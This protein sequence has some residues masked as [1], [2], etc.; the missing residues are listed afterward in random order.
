MLS[1]YLLFFAIRNQTG[2]WKQRPFTPPTRLVRCGEDSMHKIAFMIAVC[3][4][5]LGCG[6]FLPDA[7]I[8][9]RP[10][11]D[12][13]S[14]TVEDPAGQAEVRGAVHHGA[15]RDNHRLVVRSKSGVPGGAALQ[16]EK[17]RALASGQ[18]VPYQGYG[19][20]GYGL[21]GYPLGYGGYAYG[22]PY[23]LPLGTTTA[24][25]AL[26]FIPGGAIMV[27]SD[28][29]TP[30]QLDAERQKREAGEAAIIGELERGKQK[31]MK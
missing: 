17:A 23:G 4:S 19:P 3:S 2:R 24:Q 1:Y 12:Y 6:M 9:R 27:C 16:A 15:F 13:F 31:E 11:D 5:S 29:I 10:A 8:P 21:G 25:A 28:C 26:G 20:Y 7:A 30:A 18:S 14:A 22:S